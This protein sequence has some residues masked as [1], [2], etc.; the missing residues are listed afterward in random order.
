VEA[1]IGFAIRWV[2]AIEC[3]R[4]T[5]DEVDSKWF[6]LHRVETGTT[7]DWFWLGQSLDRNKGLMVKENKP[8]A[9]GRLTKCVKIWD[10]EGADTRGKCGKVGYIWA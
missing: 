1:H 9:L 6:K 4:N 8:G 2:D 3:V 5:K 7:G 10:N